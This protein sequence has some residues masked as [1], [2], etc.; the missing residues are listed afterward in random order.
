MK[1]KY[2]EQWDKLGSSDPYWAV[3]TDPEKKDGKWNR[4]DFFNTGESEVR[5]LLQK[6]KRKGEDIKFHTALDFGCG[7]GR[8]SRPLSERFRRVIAVDVSSSM[9]DEAR[10]ANRHITKIEFLHNPAANL[11]IIPDNSID[12]IYSNIVLQHMPKNRQLIYIREFCRVLRPKGIFAVQTP[13]RCDLKSWRGWA[14]RIA[15]N[16]LLNF[17]R[18]IKY[19]SSGVMEIHILPKEVVLQ[20]LAGAGM[21]VIDVERFDSAGPGF[22]S[23]MY[24]AKK[25]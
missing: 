15:G 10:R 20:T 24:F 8:L 23:Y 22:E 13:S 7:V 25:D 9:L 18:R 12:F 14:F 4:D 3:L 11:S 19:G 16:S 6:I 17:L 2:Q 1:D 21:T 5:D